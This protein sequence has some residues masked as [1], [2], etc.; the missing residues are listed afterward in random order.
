MVAFWRRGAP[1][2]PLVPILLDLLRSHLAPG[3][4]PGDEGR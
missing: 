1:V 2:P 4:I 3:Q